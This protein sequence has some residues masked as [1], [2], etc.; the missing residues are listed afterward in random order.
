M[1]K[2]GLEQA[3]YL[4]QAYFIKQCR[5]KVLGH[6][7]TINATEDV[8]KGAYVIQCRQGCF[9][10]PPQGHEVWID[11]ET[12]EICHSHRLRDLDKPG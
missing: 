2:I 7:E 3:V 4:R 9:L 11:A 8:A 5:A 12:G 10:D 6:W 1:A